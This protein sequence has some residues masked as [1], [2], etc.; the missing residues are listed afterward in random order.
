M[1]STVIAGE[2]PAVTTDKNVVHL[3]DKGKRQIDYFTFPFG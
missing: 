1:A 3:P 2:I